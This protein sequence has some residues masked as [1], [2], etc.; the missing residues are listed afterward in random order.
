MS[1]L[2]FYHLTRYASAAVWA[3]NGL[4]C[5]LLHLAPRHEQIV[6]RILGPVRTFT[7]RE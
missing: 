1:R 2:T 7:A 5:K 3:A 6:A 4:L